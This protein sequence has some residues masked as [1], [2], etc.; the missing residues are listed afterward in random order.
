MIM[1]KNIMN[2]FTTGK[3]ILSKLCVTKINDT[4]ERKRKNEMFIQS[5]VSKNRSLPFMR[6]TISDVAKKISGDSE[7]HSN[8]N[9]ILKSCF[10]GT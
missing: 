10:E 1:M 8:A 7:K 6:V 9:Y 2:I 4:R 5:C 3:N